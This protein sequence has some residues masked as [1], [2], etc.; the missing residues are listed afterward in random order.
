MVA[1]VLIALLPLAFAIPMTSYYSNAS[2][3]V[4]EYK[5]VGGCAGDG[6]GA[7][8]NTF[9]NTS[10]FKAISSVGTV[11]TGDCEFNL[12]MAA[13]GSDIT[14]I[15]GFLAPTVD[16]GW[17]FD[18]QEYH[19]Y[20]QADSSSNIMI[21]GSKGGAINSE[22]VPLVGV[23]N[24]VNNIRKVLFYQTDQWGETTGIGG[25]YND[26]MNMTF[27]INSTSKSCFWVNNTDSKGRCLSGTGAWTAPFNWTAMGSTSS[28][29]NKLGIRRLRGYNCSLGAPQTAA[30]PD[31]SP[32]TSDSTAL[33]NSA[34]KINEVVNPSASF[35]DGTSLSSIWASHNQSGLFA[36]F[37]STNF[38]GTVTTGNFSPNVT[39][40]LN[41]GSVVGFRFTAND[42]LGY[43][44]QSS[45]F[46][47]TVADTTPTFTLANNNTAAK[48]NEVVQLSSMVNDSDTLSTIIASWNGSSSGLWINISNMTISST[49]TNYS[50]NV[51]VGRARGNTV[52]WLFYSNDT[53]STFTASSLNTFVVVDTLGTIVI[54]INNTSPKINEVVNVS[55]NC[56]DVDGDF[57]LGIIAHNQSG[58]PHTNTSFNIGS[59]GIYANISQAITLSIG[60]AN[61]INFTGY[62]NDTVNTKYQSSSKITITNTAPPSTSVSNA[63]DQQFNGNQTINWTP[64]TD[65][66]SD[67]VNYI[68]RFE[69]IN[70]PTVIIQ[71]STATSFITN[72]TNET[73]YFVRIDT[74]DGYDTTLGTVIF[75]L[76]L[77]TTTPIWAE[78]FI[79]NSSFYRTSSNI[80]YTCTDSNLF[81]VNTTVY[82]RAGTTQ[83][84]S[85]GYL[86]LTPSSGGSKTINLTIDTTLGD[87]EYNATRWCGDTKNKELKIDYVTKSYSDGVSVFT[88]TRSGLQINITDGVLF[89]NVFLKIGEK[90]LTFAKTTTITDYLNK[91]GEVDSYFINA[92]YTL[93]KL[94]DLQLGIDSEITYNSIVFANQIKANAPITQVSDGLGTH[95]IIGSGKNRLSYDT[96][97]LMS[98][99]D[100]TLVQIGSNYYVTQSPKTAVKTKL[101]EGSV[102]TI[103]KD[104]SIVTSAE[105]VA[106]LVEI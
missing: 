86:N 69:A 65:V 67:T 32:P 70:P 38:T 22:N 37:S 93:P 105:K 39:N 15:T 62:C 82:N 85:I 53:I 17:C 55:V 5:M 68:V 56:T 12:S 106:K 74:T 35:T 7:V 102:I 27:M 2:D 40:T 88:D 4:S 98:T 42:T 46:I 66:D 78:S 63:S 77:D 87:G 51:T 28:T 49:G 33:N 14:L 23:I 92:K 36:N 75:N 41:R 104:S 43:S 101:A 89:K 44:A 11:Q 50:V 54:G 20:S 83:Q 76:T 3:V 13:T 81:E 61:V 31:T 103:G 18:W 71:N 24:G 16:V 19:Y 1:L 52:G 79:S 84:R 91:Q 10:Y 30:P 97:D 26:W 8:L 29:S 95:L 90:D 58:N 80:T 57:S 34:P 72:M 73:T 100:T 25:L 47:Y 96:S 21:G 59:S 9:K 45:I 99:F 60:R 6:S 64:I 94:A 48:I